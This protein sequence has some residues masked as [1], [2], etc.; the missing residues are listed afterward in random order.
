MNAATSAAADRVAPHSL[1]AARRR[2]R[3]RKTESERD[4]GNR[5]AALLNA[6]AKLFRAQG[7]AAT[8]TRDIAK[9]VGMHSGSPFY[10]FEHKEALLE[11][12]MQQGME[13]AISSQTAVLQSLSLSEQQSEQIPGQ[14]L[15]NASKEPFGTLQALVRH[16]FEVLLGPESDFI[17]VMLYEWRS[18]TAAAQLRIAGLQTQYEAA[19]LPL[20][21]TLHQQGRLRGD[22]KLARLLMF[23]ALNWC[24]QWYRREGDASLDELTAS[25]MAMLIHEAKP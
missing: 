6:A 25:A 8:T 1:T 20:L 7:F 23:G 22:L 3:P 21:Q 13:R 14:S 4:D 5:R 18:L 19:W 9:A 2:G 11:A 16:H 15:K 17:P 10:H 12:V 24:A